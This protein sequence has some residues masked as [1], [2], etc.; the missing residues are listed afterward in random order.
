MAIWDDVLD[1]EDKK[2]FL[3]SNMGGTRDFGKVPALLIVDMTYGFTD[4]KFRLGHSETGYP[5]VEATSHLLQKARKKN[6]PI[7]F[8]IPFSESHPSGIGLWKGG[9]QKTE[10]ENT[11]VEQITPFANEVVL[12]KRRPSAFFGTSLVDMLIFHGID[13]L[14]ITGL[15]TSGCVRASVV[16]AFSYNYKVVVPEEC[17]GDRSQI[18]HKISLMDIHMKYGDVLKLADIL[19]WME[20]TLS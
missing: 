19:K 1:E 11:I 15:T 5:A 18:S 6:I 16:D 7:F 2:R 4:S 8:T 14:I 10:E 9:E 20:Q 17:V 13:S 3:K 12:Q